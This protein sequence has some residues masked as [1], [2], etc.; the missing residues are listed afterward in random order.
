VVFRDTI[1]G[2]TTTLGTV[3]PDGSGLAR[4]PVTFR[5]VG[6]HSITARY[7]GNGTDAASAPATL[8]QTV[9][10]ANA[11]LALRITPLVVVPGATVTV[12]ITATA[13]APGSGIPAGA[14]SVYDGTTLVKSGSLVATTGVQTV[15]IKPLAATGAHGISVSTAGTANFMP[16]RSAPVT[17]TVKKKS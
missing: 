12:T 2:T 7:L 17:V 16:S 10:R 11:A 5:R 6:A 1:G 13:V 3:T 4:L 8:V 9:I 14:F 15:V